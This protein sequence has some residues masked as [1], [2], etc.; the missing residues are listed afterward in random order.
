MLTFK[1]AVLEGFGSSETAKRF[2]AAKFPVKYAWE[3]KKQRKALATVTEILQEIRK[4]LIEKYADKDKNDKP[5][6]NKQNMYT[7]TQNGPEFAREYSELLE[8]EVNV[9]TD[10]VSIPESVLNAA[11]NWSADDLEFLSYFVEIE[12]DK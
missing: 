7:F 1:N 11:G 12:M 3:I 6:I 2:Y 10:K 9:D 5:F 4:E 8:K